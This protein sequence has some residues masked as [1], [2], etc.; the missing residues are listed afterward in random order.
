LEFKN[1]HRRSKRGCAELSPDGP[2]LA[3]ILQQDSLMATQQTPRPFGELAGEA[4]SLFT[5]E[6]KTIRARITN[7]GGA[8]VSLEAPARARPAFR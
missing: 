2:A 1:R 5:L 4:A 7:Y 6:N 8:L 3:I